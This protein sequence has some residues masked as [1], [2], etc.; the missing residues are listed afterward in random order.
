MTK[1]GLSLVQV[2]RFAVPIAP[3]EE[4]DDLVSRLDRSFAKLERIATAARSEGERLDEMDRT[5][6]AKAFRGELV[7]QDPNDE[8]ASLLL[9]RIRSERE[10]DS[11]RVGRSRR[12]ARPTAS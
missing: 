1:A 8:P 9:D 6:L 2:R 11:A 5:I 4:Q 12:P 10:Q 7:P 3:F